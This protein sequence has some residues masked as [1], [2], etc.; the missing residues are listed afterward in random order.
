VVP[1]DQHFREGTFFEIY[2]KH[3]KTPALRLWRQET[4]SLSSRSVTSNR[5]LR[6]VPL[7]FRMRKFRNSERHA[8]ARHQGSIRGIDTPVERVGCEEELPCTRPGSPF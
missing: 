1:K 8:T 2:E 3:W 5:A 7:K 6:L 4:A